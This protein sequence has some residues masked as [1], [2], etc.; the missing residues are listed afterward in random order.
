MHSMYHSYYS[1]SSEDTTVKVLT[2][3]T[4]IDNFVSQLGHYSRPQA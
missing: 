1:Y 3:G 2:E 4:N